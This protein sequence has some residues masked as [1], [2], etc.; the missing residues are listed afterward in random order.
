MNQLTNIFTG[1]SLLLLIGCGEG[2]IKTPGNAM[3]KFE[4][5]KIREKFTTDSITHYPGIADPALKPILTEK[6]NLAADD[7]QHI[8]QSGIATDKDY[9]DKIEIGL[10]RFSDIYINLDTEDRERVC[11]YFEE[12]MDIVGLESSAGHLNEFMYGFDPT[13]KK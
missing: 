12:L 1:L 13:K 11:K 7:F 6:I 9:Q 10:K 5:F 2:Q 4:E 3:D 8:A